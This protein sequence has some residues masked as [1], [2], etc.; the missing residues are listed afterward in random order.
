MEHVTKHSRFLLALAFALLAAGVD[1]GCRPGSP[2]SDNPTGPSTSPMLQLSVPAREFYPLDLGNDWVYQR[3]LRIEIEFLSGPGGKTVRDFEGVEERKLIGVEEILGQP[4]VVQRSTLSVSGRPNVV[5]SWTRFR[6]D[7][8]GLYAADIPTNEPPAS[9]PALDSKSRDTAVFG[10]DRAVGDPT[11]GLSSPVG[12]AVLL[13][14]AASW[15]ARTGPAFIQRAWRDHRRKLEWIPLLLEPGAGTPTAS[16]GRPG[17][18]FPW[19]LQDLAYPL[20]PKA[21]WFNRVEPF[22]VRSEVETHEVIDTPAGRFPCY[23][24]RVDSELLDPTD[25]VVMWYGSCGRL[26]LTVHTEVL[27]LDVET[28]EMARITSDEAERLTALSLRDSSRGTSGC[29]R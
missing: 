7:H 21:T 5:T 16:S 4:Y 17:E 13:D 27:A 2:G 28:G 10:G 9:P 3:T 1:T 20:H 6:Q 19:E 29:Q 22:V 24:I 23:R 14:Q 18:I 26:A 15:V 12:G 25:R 11:R 8:A